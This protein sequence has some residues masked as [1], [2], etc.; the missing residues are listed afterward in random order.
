MTRHPLYTVLG[1]MGRHSVAVRVCVSSLLLHLAL[2]TLAL[3][4][5][6]LAECM[7]VCVCEN[8]IVSDKP[9]SAYVAPPKVSSITF[10]SHKRPRYRITTTQ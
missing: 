3:C 2:F 7:R 6:I 10:L 9:D 4:R 1:W 8:V 5:N